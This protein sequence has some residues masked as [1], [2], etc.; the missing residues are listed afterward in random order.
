MGPSL[1]A[2][3]GTS[4]LHRLDPLAK[5]AWLL[6]V[7]VVALATYHPIP[8][9]ALGAVGFAVALSAGVGTRVARILLIFAPVAASILVIQ[10]LAPAGCQDACTPFM[11]VGPFELYQEGMI[12]GLSLVG[13]LLAVET[14]ALAVIATTHPSDLF[15]ALARMRVPYVA[16]L[17]VSMTLQLIPILQREFALVLAAQ[18]A[19]GMRGSGFRAVLPSFVPVFAGAFERVQQLTIGL[20]SRAF[21]AGE[22]TSYRQIRSG[23]RDVA[24]A[25]AGL[26]AGVVGTVVAL[27]T[28]ST[29][30]TPDVLFPPAVVGAVFVLAGTLFVGVILAG[31]RSMA[32]A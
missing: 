23:P 5:L 8:L 16:N 22:R 17:M 30:R 3:R 6:A 9:L 14:F 7:V 25:I 29:D 18:R 2:E 20:E 32:R 19:R 26:V 1:A 15:A 12:H 27:S 28:W 10:S 11:R 4:W 13:R 24:V 31:I 21:G